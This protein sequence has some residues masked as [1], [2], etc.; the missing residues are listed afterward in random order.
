MEAHQTRYDMFVEIKKLRRELQVAND[1]KYAHQI[2]N[3]DI[4]P[5]DE[6]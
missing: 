1:Y 5:R 6:T 3:N 4:N 2:M